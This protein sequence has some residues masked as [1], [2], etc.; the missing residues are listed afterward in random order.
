MPKH[1]C[2]AAPLKQVQPA[3]EEASRKWGD[4]RQGMPLPVPNEVGSQQ[5]D[6][7]NVAGHARATTH[8]DKAV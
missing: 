6:T 4:G 1:A 2:H 7:A 5:L 8:T 3:A